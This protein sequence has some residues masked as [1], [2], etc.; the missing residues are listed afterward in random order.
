[1]ELFRSKAADQMIK[2]GN[3]TE[4]P[5]SYNANVLRTAKYEMTKKEYLDPNPM[6]ALSKL[7]NSEKGQNIVKDIGLDPVKVYFWSPHQNRLF[8]VFINKKMPGFA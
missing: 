3:T 7:K 2:E 6:M 8:N 1:M 4:P 5:H